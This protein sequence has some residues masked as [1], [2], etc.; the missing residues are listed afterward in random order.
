MTFKLSKKSQER[1]ETCDDRLITIVSDVLK[2]MDITIL[3]GHRGKEE[4]E[5]AFSEGKSRAH[6]GQSKHNSYPSLA[7]DIAPYPIN[8]DV[9]DPRWNIMCDLVLYVAE[10]YGIKMRL[11][12]DFTNLKDYPHVELE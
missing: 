9:K 2:V 7:V 4:Q 5:K 1:L 11:G 6:F 3:C 12:R 8:W 10:R